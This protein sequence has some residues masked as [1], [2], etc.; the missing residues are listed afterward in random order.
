MASKRDTSRETTESITREAIEKVPDIFPIYAVTQF[1]IE[2]E[3][4]LTW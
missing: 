2:K 3:S 1:F 4:T